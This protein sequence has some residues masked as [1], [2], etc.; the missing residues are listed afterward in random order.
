MRRHTRVVSKTRL[1]R[2]D[3]HLRKQRVALHEL[4]WISACAEMT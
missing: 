3:G 4:A 1:R 2:D